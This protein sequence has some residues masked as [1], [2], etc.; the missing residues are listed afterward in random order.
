[1]SYK[2]GMLRDGALENKTIIVTGGGTG[3]GKSMGAYFL[4]LGANVVICSRRLEVLETTAKELEEQTGGKVLAIA[5]DVR[6]TDEIENV[7]TKAIE[8]F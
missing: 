3:L 7:I 2:E 5:C 6:K 1:M 4:K 8:I